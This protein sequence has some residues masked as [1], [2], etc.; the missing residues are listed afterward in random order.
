M[1]KQ[2]NIFIALPNGKRDVTLVG[3]PERKNRLRRPRPGLE[4]HIKMD[5]MK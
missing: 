4:N 3:K 2:I 5:V 1:C